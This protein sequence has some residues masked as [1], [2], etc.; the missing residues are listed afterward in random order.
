MK[1][2]W[3]PLFAVVLMLTGCK[4]DILSRAE[5]GKTFTYKV[6]DSFTIKLS[7]NPSTGYV[8][9]FKTEPESQQIV[10]LISDNFEES[11]QGRVGAGGEHSFVWQAVNVGTVEIYGFHTRP[12]VVSK[13]EPTVAY[14]IM[15]Q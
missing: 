15:V 6:G 11:V 7:E 4:K 3:L 14:R 5:S 12:W 13:D 1:K 10:S 2:F 8:W 9:R